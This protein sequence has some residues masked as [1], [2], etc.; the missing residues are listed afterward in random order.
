[1]FAF[2][3]L[4]RVRKKVWFATYAIYSISVP[5]EL[6]IT[7]SPK[8]K[9]DEY[10]TIESFDNSMC[11]TSKMTDIIENVLIKM[12]LFLKMKTDNQECGCVFSTSSS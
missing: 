7:T 11:P 12:D 6:S 9:L 3:F 1:M 5:S 10:S 8:N 2:L 4:F